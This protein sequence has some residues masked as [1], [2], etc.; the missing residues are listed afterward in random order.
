[1]TT[2]RLFIPLVLFAGACGSAPSALQPSPARP[3]EPPPAA[4]TATTPVPA[5]PTLA[6]TTLA[7]WPD[8]SAFVVIS[9]GG[10]RLV[11]LQAAEETAANEGPTVDT[12]YQ[13]I[14]L[15]DGAPV[16][17]ART[18][19]LVAG[20]HTCAFHSTST[21]RAEVTA[22]ERGGALA[23][24]GMRAPTTLLVA[25][26]TVDATCPL[27]GDDLGGV[28]IASSTA[29]ATESIEMLEVTGAAA[30]RTL[31]RIPRSVTPRP[32][33]GAFV[34]TGSVDGATVIYTSTPPDID[35]CTSDE[36]TYVLRADGA[37]DAFR[38][39]PLSM[40]IQAGSPGRAHLV[41]VES[42]TDAGRPASHVRIVPLAGGPALL[43]TD[44]TVPWAER[45]NC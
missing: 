17:A 34:A 31:A 9:A 1:M 14:R 12:L 39:E 27:R 41:I 25:E 22:L 30:R 15:E 6:E 20:D 40:A 11:I 5:E 3:T 24:P 37:A 33:A 38:G 35:D 32:P 10:R 7:S 2:S 18:L 19:Y 29:P 44:I 8:G 43:D 21:H 36:T 4:P 16:T 28:A 23:M 26:G 45:L 42:T 13:H